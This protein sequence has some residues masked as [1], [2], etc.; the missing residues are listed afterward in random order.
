MRRV[1]KKP[2]RVVGHPEG[3]PKEVRSLSKRSVPQGTDSAPITVADSGICEELAEY[4]GIKP[5]T[6]K[7]A[8]LDE[9]AQRVLGVASWAIDKSDVP[10]ERAGMVIAWAKKRGAGAFRPVPDEYVSLAEAS[11]TARKP[12]IGKMRHSLGSLPGTG[13]STPTAWLTF[14]R[15]W[16]SG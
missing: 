10:E 9:P 5:S 7:T 1:K 2:P 4:L 3:R 14:S 8:F 6:A 11:A 12:T 15:N 16:R 13:T